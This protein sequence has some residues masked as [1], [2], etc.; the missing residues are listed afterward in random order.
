MTDC[1]P[2]VWGRCVSCGEKIDTRTDTERLDWL[3]ENAVRLVDERERSYWS[4]L[5]T[6]L[7]AVS[8]ATTLRKAID[9][10]LDANE[11]DE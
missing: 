2:V 6:S 5:D 3:E 11:S 1:G 10:A 8:H 4:C 7:P 9:A